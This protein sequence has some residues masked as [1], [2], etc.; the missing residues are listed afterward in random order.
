M[1]RSIRHTLLATLRP[2]LR[3][4]WMLLALLAAGTAAPS[5]GADE[6]RARYLRERAVCTSGQ[7]RSAR[8]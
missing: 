1:S 8:R 2:S 3:P 4:P 5:F 6:A 7:S